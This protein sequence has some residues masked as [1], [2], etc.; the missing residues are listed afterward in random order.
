MRNDTE[1]STVVTQAE[2]ATEEMC[3]GDVAKH[4]RRRCTS[5]LT[6]IYSLLTGGWLQKEPLSPALSGK[7]HVFSVSHH[8]ATIYKGPQWVGS[9]RCCLSF[10]EWQH[11]VG[12]V[13]ATDGDERPRE[14]LLSTQYLRLF[15]CLLQVVDSIWEDAMSQSRLIGP[16]SNA[17]P[18]CLGSCPGT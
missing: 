14:K 11:E 8:I 16:I 9:T 10:Q 2:Y 18:I 4:P 3:G 7:G 5:W 17:L 1:G 6:R 15:R 13:L 12:I